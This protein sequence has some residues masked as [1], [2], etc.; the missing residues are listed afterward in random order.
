VSETAGE[1]TVPELGAAVPE[2]DPEHEE[3]Q[4]PNKDFQ[5]EEQAEQSVPRVSTNVYMP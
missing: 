2:D 1:T 5:H 3:E 4:F